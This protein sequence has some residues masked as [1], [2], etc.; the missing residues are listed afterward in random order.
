MKSITK[1]KHIRGLKKSEMYQTS[2]ENLTGFG[3][4]LIFE[5]K[6]EGCQEGFLMNIVGYVKPIF[7][8]LILNYSFLIS[9]CF[10]EW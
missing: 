5:E 4:V 1:L 2:R 3:L 9:N 10:S 6:F 7:F 8:S